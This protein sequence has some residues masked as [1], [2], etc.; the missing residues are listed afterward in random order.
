MLLS[1]PPVKLTLK[2][3]TISHNV[4]TASPSVTVQGGGLYTTL[5]TTFDHN[6]IA[7]NAPDQCS[8]C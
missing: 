8:G 1:G 6:E 5:P 3:F 4:L 7:N 2:D